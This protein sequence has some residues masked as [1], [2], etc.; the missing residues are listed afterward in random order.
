MRILQTE[1]TQE[2]TVLKRK[3]KT[4]RKTLE[5]FRS[6]Y[7]SI[8]QTIPRRGKPQNFRFQRYTLIAIRQCL[9]K[10]SVKKLN[11]EI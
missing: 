11:P 5:L 7:T 10:V 6:K 1:D 4:H 9:N 3:I 8:P 2:F